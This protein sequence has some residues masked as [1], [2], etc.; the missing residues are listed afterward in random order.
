VCGRGA[1]ERFEH[2]VKGAPDSFAAWPAQT[3]NYTES[4]DDKTWIDAIT[5]NADGNG[6]Q[7][8]ID[9]CR[10]THLMCAILMTS[11]GMPMLAAGQDFMRSKQG[12]R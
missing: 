5:E 1:P 10:R 4:H 8:T 2:F 11:I 3:V 9:D 6:Q 7:P 12:V